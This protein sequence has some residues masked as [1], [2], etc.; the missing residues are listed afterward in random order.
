LLAHSST[1]IFIII[2]G[3]VCLIILPMVNRNYNPKP[4][5][6]VEKS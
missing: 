1:N 4:K 3:A 5:Q 6:E 2:V